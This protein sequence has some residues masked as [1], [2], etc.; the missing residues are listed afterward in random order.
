MFL[1]R[2][3]IIISFSI[4]L[5]LLQC[6]VCTHATFGSSQPRTALV[7]GNG[8]YKSAPLNNPVNDA[9]DIALVL[10]KQGFTVIHRE[11]A[12]RSQMRSAVREFEDILARKGGTG[13]FYFAGHGVQLQGENFLVP[14]GADVQREYEVPD[15]TI[16]ADLVL[17]AMAY[18][19]NNLNIVI[20]DACRNNPFPRS[21]RS[22]SRGLARMKTMGSGMLIAYATSPGSVASDGV[23]K[24]GI[25]TKHLLKAMET[26]GLSIEQVFKSVRQGVMQE[27]NNNQTPWEESSLTGDFYFIKIDNATITV[28]TPPQGDQ[29]SAGKGD[30]KELMLWQGISN[31]RNVED[32][33]EYLDHYPDGVF[34]ELAR[35]RVKSL[36]ETSGIPIASGK[37][38]K[39]A[40]VADTLIGSWKLDYVEQSK[41][42]YLM[43]TFLADGKGDAEGEEP[44]GTWWAGSLTWSLEGKELT[45]VY[46][47]SKDTYAIEGIMQESMVLLGMHGNNKGERFALNRVKEGE[48]QLDLQRHDHTLVGTWK[49]AWEENG[50]S[51]HQV[52]T[53]DQDGSA[54][55][56]GQ[57]SD[58]TWSDKGKWHV[59]D[60]N[61]LMIVSDGEIQRYSVVHATDGYLDLID[62]SV[63]Y[64]GVGSRLMRTDND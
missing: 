8:A 19:N 20:L 16:Q 29:I 58:S 51:A 56:R 15:Q 53:L 30:K 18:A 28:N 12:D 35:Q 5:V 3:F 17:K 34:A 38:E 23:G 4:V 59:E 39:G 54:F 9:R 46:E 40:A 47:E 50:K 42:S 55:D 25:Y 2:V 10:K 33:K 45:V 62:L 31:S 41:E 21:F 24:N 1:Q 57:T 52:I 37:K 7:I 44:D 13:L 22:A 49:D 64:M 11:N 32:F 6:F 43:F 60:N 27:T 36:S 63:E 26:S 14:I 48:T 61:I